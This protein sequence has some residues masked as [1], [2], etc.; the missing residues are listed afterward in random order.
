MTDHIHLRIDKTTT[1][2]DIH[3][4]L[5]EAQSR[6]KSPGA[7][8]L[9]ARESTYTPPG[10]EQCKVTILYLRTGRENALEWLRNTFKRKSQYALAASVLKE[11]GK[12]DVDAIRATPQ[13]NSTCPTFKPAP[14]SVKPARRESGVL[15][16]ALLPYAIPSPA[17]P[18]PKLVTLDADGLLNNQQIDHVDCLGRDIRFHNAGGVS[19]VSRNLIRSVAKLSSEPAAKGKFAEF[20]NLPGSDPAEVEENFQCFTSLAVKLYDSKLPASKFVKC[21]GRMSKLSSLQNGAAKFSLHWARCWHLR[22]DLHNEML[23]SQVAMID[24][25]VIWMARNYLSQTMDC[26]ALE[27]LPQWGPPANDLVDVCSLAACSANR[28][29]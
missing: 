10:G 14:G 23:Y 4:F 16:S 15:F 11:V 20:L 3:T 18:Q 6:E 5:L 24:R 2:G 19:N 7:L 13:S 8:H 9:R 21:I 26:D 12:F 28:T 17:I 1:A 22:T 25:F 29:T 27:A